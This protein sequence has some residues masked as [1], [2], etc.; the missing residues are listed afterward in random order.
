MS[1][2]GR[3]EFKENNKEPPWLEFDNVKQHHIRRHVSAYGGRKKTFVQPPDDVPGV[4]RSALRDIC[5][6]LR[7]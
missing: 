2:G 6:G 3:E 7:K 1:E 5:N 4:S